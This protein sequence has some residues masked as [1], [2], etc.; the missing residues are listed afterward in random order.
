[1]TKTHNL[2]AKL[3]Q[4]ITGAGAVCVCGLL[5]FTLLS[6]PAEAQNDVGSIVGYVT[7]QSGA[8][9]P[10][11]TVVATNEGTG[12]K[13][14]VTSDAQ[15][16]YALPNLVPA[17]YTLS[18]EAK[19][20]QKFD[21][22]HNTL[23]SNS[24]IAIDA[25]LTVGETSQTVEVTGTA[26]LL[27]TQSAA[28]QSE[29]TG[30]QVQK[31]EL[32]GRNPIYMTQFLP[33]V[34]STSTLGDFNYAFNSGDS[35]NI[36]GARTQDTLYTIDG[37]PAVRTRDDGEIIAGVK[38]EAVQEMQIL[39]A[40]YSAE[41]GG[42]SGAQVRIVT[43]SGTRDFHGVAYEYLRNSA[44]NANTWQRNLTPS[45]RFAP[46]F[47]YNNFGFAIGGPVWA[48]GIPFLDKLR[49]RFFFFV[50]EDW[51]R[52][53]QATT[54]QGT[55]PT[56]L[57]REGNFSELLN[58]SNPYYTGVTQI[59]QPGSCPVAGAPTCVAY[60]G[61]I[62]PQ[63]EWSANGMAIINAF[64]QP[65]AG[66][67]QGSQNWI[68][69]ASAPTNQRI[70]QIN[71]D[72][73]ITP[74]EHI[75]F[76]R[77][78]DSYSSLSP[79]STTLNLIQ[80]F[81][82]R[83]NQTIGL[84]LTST[85]SPTMIN[86]AH[87]TLSIDDVYNSLEAT[88]PGLDRGQYGINF[89]YIVSGDKSAENKIPTVSLP[90]FTSLAGGPYPSR[91]SG[92]IYAATDSFTKVWGKHTIKAG[93]FW[94]YMGENDNDQ[95]NVSTVPGGASNQNGTFYLTDQRNGYN[96]TTGV[97]LA[98]MAVGLADYYT[99]IGTRAFTVWRGS[100]WEE[101][102]Q[103]NFQ[104]T[105]RLNLD[106]GIRISTIIP[107][108]ALW[109]NSVYFNPASYSAANAP[110]V[111][112]SGNVVL[113]TGNPYD[114]MVIPGF[115]KFPSAALEDNRVPAANPA[116][117]ACA[118]QPCNGL[119]APNLPKGFSPT[120]T[121]VDPRIGLAYQLF[122]KTVFRFG[123]GRFVENKGIIDN[124]FPGGNSPFQPTETVYNVHMDNPGA[125]I[126]PG[127]QPPITVTS[128]NPHMKPPNRWNWN[129]TVQQELPF[130]SSFQLAYVGARGNHNWDV[131]DVNQVPAGTLNRNPGVNLSQLRPYQG[132]TSIQQAQSGVNEFYSSLQ[133][134]FVH[135]SA[136]STLQL[137]YT[138]AK[139]MDNGSN[140]HTIVP[141]TYYTKNLWGPSEFDIRHVFIANYSYALPFFRGQQ[142]LV[143]KIAG[144][145][146]LSGSTQLQS[147]L[148]CSVGVQN[149]YAGVGEFGSFNCEPALISSS[150]GQ[151]VGQFWVKNGRVGTPHKFAGPNG[152][153]GSP[154]WFQTRQGNNALF[155][156]PTPG[157]FN[158][159]SGI[160]DD[161]Y[162]P[163]LQNW[164]LALIKSFPVFREDQLQFRAQAY[165]WINHPNLA[166]PQY[167]PTSPQ[168]GEV[169][170]KTTSNPR[171][172]QVGLRLSF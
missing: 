117:N 47:T 50:N 109:A 59:Y 124:I 122:P 154:S 163:G 145:W 96:A 75:T 136:H 80:E 89:P 141:D 102:A 19:G 12:E 162:A 85:I 151:N 28:V 42:A 72:I 57:M 53:R 16:H 125:S 111:N 76:R 52:Y 86:E 15:G 31:Q 112:S 137:S 66:Y 110:Q 118:G 1:L 9:V 67:Q 127:T 14:T 99:E 138:W 98:N 144:G 157:T 166:T 105:P 91:S 81:Q 44:M 74:N 132:F 8:A 60:P 63:S 143:G 142:N 134:G 114:G 128:M 69:A 169:T 62:I 140:Y 97:A 158:T 116:N 88:S 131:F 103:D 5:L 133:A 21:S 119:F 146:E 121:N 7:D 84:G 17:P 25:K 46:Q 45:T 165:N 23:A 58:P 64:P 35:F 126:S 94:D 24:T 65:T 37:A 70:G 108:H 156:P 87:F 172:L 123:G 82:T 135:R 149:D 11:A 4:K 55:V 39:T 6:R 30:D 49:N 148:P 20:F 34:V 18:V 48:P 155:T 100:M 92:I 77:S 171:T 164:N 79:F 40:D 113:G 29:V 130:Q 51:A 90:I 32:N 73:L 68:G 167:I 168:F 10:G 120:T 41:Y 101:F 161:I 107:P 56:A 139:D 160:R 152:T 26:A 54:S 27:Q 153:T 13:R 2:S 104:V 78:D 38:S 33:G 93:I 170:S 3:R 95:I 106:F 115:S 147:G 159:Q 129:V 150:T 43:K 61:N 71:G 36:N 83:P 22:T